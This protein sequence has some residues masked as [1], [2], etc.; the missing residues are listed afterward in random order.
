MT[1]IEIL[2]TIF[3]VL[4]LVKLILATLL[5]ELWMEV[6]YAILQKVVVITGIYLMLAV[7]VGYYVLAG[8]SIVQVAS[9]MLWTS[10]LIG[11]GLAPYSNIIL[12]LREEI[13]SVGLSKAWLAMLIWA[14]IA[15]WVLYAVFTK[16]G[17]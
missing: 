8:L 4:V 15:I 12:K 7:I 1:S 2:A 14:V 9:V 3:A 16:T 6:T 5:P 11:V 17:S 13:L 10:L